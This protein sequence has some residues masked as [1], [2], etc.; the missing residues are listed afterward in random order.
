MN[1]IIIRKGKPSDI[2]GIFALVQEFAPSYEPQ[3]DKFIN[4]LANVLNDDSAF[5]CVAQQKEQVVG[6]CLGFD[7]CGWGRTTLSN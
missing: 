4:S 3:K 1:E 2:D 5:L 6:Y 7:F